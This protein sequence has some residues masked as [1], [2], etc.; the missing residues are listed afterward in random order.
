LSS[1]RPHYHRVLLKLSGE[2]M[3]GSQKFGL[4]YEA[5]QSIAASLKEVIDLGVKIAIVVG[6][7]NIFRGVQAKAFGFER[8]PADQIGMVATIINGLALQQTLKAIG[9]DA[10]VMSAVTCSGIVENYH[11]L[12]AQT[13]FDKGGIPIF[14]GGT[15]NPYFTTDTAASLRA[16]EIHADVLMKATKVEGIFDKDPLKHTD[17]KQ[18]RH[19]TYSQALS[20]KLNVMDATAL[21]MC[22][23]N[24]IPIY[25]FNIF[26]PGALLHAILGRGA[27][28]LV[29]EE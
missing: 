9:L 3:M 6:G 21:A 24:K 10:H 12:K 4:D 7:G 27:G 20:N 19:V 28:S 17:A 26:H 14:V 11:W 13:L 16:S 18:L 25:V 22:R 2:A 29:S 15:G 8:T 23:E 1:S 5:C